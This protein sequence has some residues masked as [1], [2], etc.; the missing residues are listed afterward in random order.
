MA[1]CPV[2]VVIF[3]VVVVFVAIGF[4]AIGFVAIGFV[5]KMTNCLILFIY[6]R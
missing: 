3:I 5:S 2:F 4:V 1:R 6:H